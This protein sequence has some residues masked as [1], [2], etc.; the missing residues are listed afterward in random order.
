MPPLRGSNLLF[1][2]PIRYR[3]YGAFFNYFRK[4]YSISPRWGLLLY[5]AYPIR[6]RPDGANLF[7]SYVLFD[8]APMGL[9]FFISYILFDAAPMGLNFFISYI[10]FDAA[11]MGLTFLD[12]YFYSMPPRWGLPLANAICPQ[13]YPMPPLWGYG[14]FS[15]Y[16]TLRARCLPRVHEASRL[17]G[18]Q[19]GIKKS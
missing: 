3:S 5:F 12:S 16:E 18:K 8:A 10:L 6:F 19:S 14:A 2:F 17:A 1:V 11:P 7:I 4:F 9:N 15:S 13:F